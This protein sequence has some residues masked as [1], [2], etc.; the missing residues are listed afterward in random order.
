M[1]VVFDPTC[2]ACARAAELQSRQGSLPLDVV[3][4]AEDQVASDQY[5][6]RIHS[7]ARITI[8]PEARHALRVRAVPAAFLVADGLVVSR[9]TI[10]GAEDLDRVAARCSTPDEA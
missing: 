1:V 8:S 7:E 10:T 9:S 5:A 3:W 6:E 4:V 2:P